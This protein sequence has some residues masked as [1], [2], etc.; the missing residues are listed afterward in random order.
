MLI[1]CTPNGCVSFVSDAFEGSISDP[2]I[3]KRSK[4]LDLLQSGDVVRAYRGFT[5][6]D[7]LKLSKHI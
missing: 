4:I 1:G 3:F 5:V 6:H 7:E 2:E